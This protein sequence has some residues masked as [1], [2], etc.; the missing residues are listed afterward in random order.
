MPKPPDR[1]PP[2]DY[3]SPKRDPERAHALQMAESA[4]VNGIVEVDEETG[5]ELPPRWPSYGDVARE[6]KIPIFVV[7]ET[8]AKYNWVRRRLQRQTALQ[9]FQNEQMARRW[10]SSDRAISDALTK[11]MEALTGVLARK[12]YESVRAVEIAA[13]EES[14]QI[15]EGNPDAL[16]RADVKQSELE[17]LFRSHK[18]L[19][20]TQ[21]A[22]MDRAYTLPMS[23]DEI[24]LAPDAL[25]TV[26]QEALDKAEAL[27]QALPKASVLDVYREILSLEQKAM[28][29]ASTNVIEGQVEDD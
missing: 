15:A 19:S 2:T 16:V 4:F 7:N 22:A 23:P 9:T 27:E 26:E 5:Q 14:R 21:K 3:S 1:L 20:D 8:G 24:P 28:D 10:V 13:K 25:P 6:Y 29:L 12:V 11:N 17:S 18:A